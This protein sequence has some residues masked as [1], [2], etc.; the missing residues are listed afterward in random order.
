MKNRVE[1]GVSRPLGYT[2]KVERM[3]GY[4]LGEG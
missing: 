2:K 4:E 1:R 3:L